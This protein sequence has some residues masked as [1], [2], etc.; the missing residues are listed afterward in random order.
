MR[1][2][3]FQDQIPC[4]LNGDL[5]PGRA[6]VL[7]AHLVSCSVCRA[8]LLTARVPMTDLPI[9]GPA[10]PAFWDPMNDAIFAELDLSDGARGARDT[11]ALVKDWLNAPFA[12]RRAALFSVG[13]A[14]AVALFMGRGDVLT[15]PVTAQSTDAAVIAPAPTTAPVKRSTAGALVRPA[16]YVPHRGSL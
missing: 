2:S 11:S 10:D 1:C 16:S 12:S 15:P 13:L 3:Q 5:A 6:S 7:G 9:A 8:L 14:I 4:F